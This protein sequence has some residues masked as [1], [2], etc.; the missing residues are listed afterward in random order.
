MGIIDKGMS[1]GLATEWIEIIGVEK[2]AG[3]TT[4]SVLRPSGLK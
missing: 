4:V 2:M 3:Q 1:L